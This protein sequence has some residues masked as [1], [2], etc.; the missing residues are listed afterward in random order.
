MSAITD[1]GLIPD[2]STDN[3]AALQAL[4]E[5]GVPRLRDLNAP[6]REGRRVAKDPLAEPVTTPRHGAD[7]FDEGRDDEQDFRA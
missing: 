6:E 1:H 2:G 3:T 5:R 4:F 7:A